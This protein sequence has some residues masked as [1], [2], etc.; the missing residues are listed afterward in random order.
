MKNNIILFVVCLCACSCGT[1]NEGKTDTGIK[2]MYFGPA[3]TAKV[4]NAADSIVEAVQKMIAEELKKLKD[5][6]NKKNTSN[7]ELQRI[8]ADGNRKYSEETEEVKT[9]WNNSINSIINRQKAVSDKRHLLEQTANSISTVLKQTD[10]KKLKNDL[11]D[12]ALKKIPPLT[13]EEI[14]FFVTENFK[15]SLK[16]VKDSLTKF[17]VA[18]EMLIIDQNTIAYDITTEKDNLVLHDISKHIWGVGNISRFHSGAYIL[19]TE[20]RDTLK[21]NMKTFLN[22]VF[23]TIDNNVGRT[24]G[25]SIYYITLN[26]YVD[27]YA[28]SQDFSDALSRGDKEK[29]KKKNMDLSQKRADT[30]MK[31][32]FEIYALEVEKEEE[33]NK[34]IKFMPPEKYSIGR[35]EEL[36]YKDGI[37]KPDGEA[38]PDRRIT[39]LQCRFNAKKKKN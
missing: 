31:V 24:T 19:D 28:D 8:E 39:K 27:G 37:Y 21:N 4:D 1:S 23:L 38:D 5:V 7:F 15:K 32:F 20:D 35:G 13:T 33:R 6:N 26:I 17:D 14:I 11:I 9:D 25:D 30:I 2:G 22:S 12:E 29:R 18:I 34:K 36:P 10:F 16:D 3:D